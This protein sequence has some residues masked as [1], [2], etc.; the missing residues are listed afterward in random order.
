MALDRYLNREEAT[1]LDRATRTEQAKLDVATRRGPLLRVT[2][3]ASGTPRDV[4]HGLAITPTGFLVL[5]ATGPVYRA[6][7]L[8]WNEQRAWLQADGTNVEAVVCFLVLS[9]DTENA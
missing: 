4:A 1:A 2:F 3:P 8:E 5:S 9:E 6:P 7:N